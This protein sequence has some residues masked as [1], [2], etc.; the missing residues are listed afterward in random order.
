MAMINKPLVSIVSPCYNSEKWIG[1]MLDSILV[2]TYKNIE[3]IC[4][5]DGSTDNTETVITS[6]IELFSQKGMRLIYT[7][8]LHYGQTAAVN[9]GLKLANGE[10]LSWIDSDDFLTVNSIEKKMKALIQNSDFGIVTSNF[11][12]VEEKSIDKIIS[13]G[14][15]RLGNLNYQPY[16][17]YLALSEMSIIE[18]NCHIIKTTDFDT[19]F[20]NRQIVDCIEGQN[21]QLV[22]PLYYRFKRLYIDEPLAYYV[23]RANSHYHRKRS[24]EELYNRKLGLTK[25]LSKVLYNIGLTQA[26]ANRCIKI[27]TFTVK[28]EVICPK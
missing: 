14:G 17:F 22:L 24:E 23:I 18:S 9:T 2:Q 6:Y 13:V 3:M 21:F 28:G 27:S 4:I 19:V 26:E 5:D 16:Q 1:R 11:N 25:M 15:S 12:I 7:K 20:P 10:Y 8:Q